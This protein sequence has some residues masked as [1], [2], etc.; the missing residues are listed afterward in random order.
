[1]PMRKPERSLLGSIPEE[2]Q[3]SNRAEALLTE[4]MRGETPW[5]SNRSPRRKPTAG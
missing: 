5:T 2:G 3:G 4:L 1:M